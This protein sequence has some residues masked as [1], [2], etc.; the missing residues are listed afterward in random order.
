MTQQVQQLEGTMEAS[1]K[2]RNQLD[3]LFHQKNTD[4]K[5]VE[6]RVEAAYS[7]FFK[8]F[9]G[10][11]YSTLKKMAELQQKS[12]TNQ[13]NEEL[14]ELDQLMTETI[15]RL[16]KSKQLIHAIV[17]D[18]PL[19]KDQT[20]ENECA[21]SQLKILLFRKHHTAKL[22]IIG[23]HRTRNR[24]RVFLQRNNKAFKHL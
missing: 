21:I 22:V 10:I 16:K 2:F 13:Y 20:W 5:F 7:Y 12:N 14:E 6:E 11:L 3:K 17:N 1:R 23:L 9:D 18:L 15:I 8:T 24:V 4:L 19:E